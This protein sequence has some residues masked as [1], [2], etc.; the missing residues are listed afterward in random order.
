MNPRLRIV[1]LSL[2]VAASGACSSSPASH[3][4]SPS[5]GGA[6]EPDGR[7]AGAPEEAASPT[8]IPT[9]LDLPT[10]KG[11]VHGSAA[12]GVRS[13]LGIPFGATTGGAN[14]WK[15]PQPAAAWTSPRD[16]TKLGP[17]CPQINPQT[18][19]Y[20]PTGDEDCLSLNVWTPDPAPTSPL[21]V[22]V[23][24]FGGAYE[25]GS[26]GSMPY[27]GAQLVPKGNVVVVTLNYR[28]G[29]LGFFASGALAAEGSGG[30]GNYGILDQR[31]AL[32][33]VQTNIANFGGDKNSVTLFGESAGGN[34]TCIHLVSPGS[35]G[36]FQRAIVE[37]GL[38]TKPAET[39]SGAETVGD[40]FASALGCSGSGA[41]ACLRALTPA[42]VTM[43][44]ANAPPMLPGGSFTRTT[45]RAASSSPWSTAKSYR[46]NRR[47]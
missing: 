25:F 22:M 27:G 40:A 4:S 19:G 35:Q 36:L 2:V 7:D 38:C 44:P 41:L 32:Q 12:G 11:P 37:S 45:P 20:D 8:A 17:I 18:M 46:S 5:E 10:D 42:A 15:A 29:A 30:A 9:G 23:W 28:V 16:V 21:P 26:G 3:A 13:F 1:L 31:A 14:R 34:S 33:W 6:S 47:R 39:L 43:G 24:I